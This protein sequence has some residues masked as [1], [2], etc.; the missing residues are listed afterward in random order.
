[1]VFWD[2][3]APV[4]SAGQK[5]EW[6]RCPTAGIRDHEALSSRV[7]WDRSGEKSS[8]GTLPADFVFDLLRFRGGCYNRLRQQQSRPGPG[9]KGASSF[10]APS[11]IRPAWRKAARTPPWPAP[12]SEV[13]GS[14]CCPLDK[15]RLITAI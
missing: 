4:R 11:E 5:A 6:W 7:I 13:S 12:E 10:L 8:Q 1:M 9:R 2:W 14:V 15:A 3:L